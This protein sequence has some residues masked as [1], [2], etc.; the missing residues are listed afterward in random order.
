M[1]EAVIRSECGELFGSEFVAIFETS[2]IGLAER[3]VA[4]GVFVEERVREEQ[5]ALCDGR[6]MRYQRDFAETAGAVVGVNHALKDFLSTGGGCFDDASGLEA[7]GDLFDHGSL[8]GKRLGAGD[9][10]F[11]AVFM[12]SGEDLF[13]GHVGDAV[14]SVAG[15]GA[16]AKPEMVVGEADAQVGA[17]GAEVKGRVTLLD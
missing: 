3:D 2:A 9:G 16:S 17:G 5:G 6:G 10:A 13:R 15:G 11:D 4:G 1:N 7:D 8:M 12:R 14:A